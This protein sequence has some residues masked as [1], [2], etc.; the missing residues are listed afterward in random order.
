[1]D[2]FPSPCGVRRVRDLCK[3]RTN[4]QVLKFSDVSVPLR[5]KEGAGPELMQVNVDPQHTFPSPCGVRRVRDV[6]FANAFRRENVSFRP[7]AG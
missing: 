7:L 6:K 2:K 1:M 5:G 3:I 4:G